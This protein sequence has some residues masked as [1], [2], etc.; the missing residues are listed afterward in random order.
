[1]YDSSFLWLFIGVSAIA[2][3]MLSFRIAS[4]VVFGL[5]LLTLELVSLRVMAL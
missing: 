4:I 3:I 2:G 1:M 5:T